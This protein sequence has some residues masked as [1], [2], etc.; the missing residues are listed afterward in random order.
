MDEK[1]IINDGWLPE[2][3]GI[4]ETDYIAGK[5]SGRAY[6]MARASGGRISG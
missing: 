1:E 3:N 2:P 5:A 6:P 4:R